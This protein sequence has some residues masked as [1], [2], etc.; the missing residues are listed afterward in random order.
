MSE[1]ITNTSGNNEENP[2]EVVE[3]EGGP[4]SATGAYI[5]RDKNGKVVDMVFPDELEG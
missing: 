1:K 3:W 2:M 5:G 4:D